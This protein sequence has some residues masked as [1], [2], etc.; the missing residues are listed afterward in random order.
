MLELTERAVKTKE[1]DERNIRW[2]RIE[3]FDH[4]EYHICDV[5]EVNKS[6][7]LL[8]KFA[9]NQQI[10]LHRH[11]AAYRTLVLQ[12]ELRIYR[13]NGEVKE[14]RPVGSYVFTPAGGEP[15]REGGGDQ[16]VIV[17]F[18]NR[19]VD[20]VIYEIL[21]DELNTITTFGIPEFKALLEGQRA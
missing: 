21:D 17:F 1:F 2:N 8:F 11:H 9:A 18:S 5:D 13:A 4:I 15:H 20:G 7:D 3:G 6:V 10:V 16:D 19:N 12:G 14:I